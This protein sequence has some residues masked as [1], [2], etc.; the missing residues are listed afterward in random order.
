M[1]AIQNTNG[2][3]NSFQRG[4]PPDALLA[5]IAACGGVEEYYNFT[6][7]E[8][9]ANI[10]RFRAMSVANGENSLRVQTP[11]PENA[12]E[13]VESAVTEIAR[14]PLGITQEFLSEGLVTPLPNWWGI[15]S[16]RRDRTGQAGRAHR[17]MVPDSRGERFVLD[18]NGVSWPVFC[19]WANFSFNIRELAVGQRVGTPLDVSHSE[20]ATYLVQEAN[21]DQ[22]INGLTDEQGN[23]T[24]IDGM[25]APGLLNSTLT[26]SYSAWSGLTGAQILGEVQD[27]IE[28]LRLTH[29]GMPFT[30]FVPSN[31]SKI[32]TS[33]YGTAYPK[34]LLARLEELGPW[35]GRNLRV[36]IVDT[37]PNN[38]AVIVAM[39]KRAVDLLVGQQPVPISWKDGP[40]FNT[41]WVVMDCVVFRMFQNKNGDYGVAV[42]DVA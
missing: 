14:K 1:R 29:P 24:T 16:V 40:G 39:D 6:I 2:F 38:R 13:V 23:A 20:W 10:Q 8:E 42:G 25:S 37:L 27:A 41:Y 17:T 3:D 22:V 31:F 7:Q 26:W 12:H 28:A 21:E 18:R 30:L 35:G 4:V 15:P 34:S 32:I 11:F 5:G 9:R 36:R 33:D 19:T